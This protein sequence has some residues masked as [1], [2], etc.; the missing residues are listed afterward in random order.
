VTSTTVRLRPLRWWDLDAVLELERDLFEDPWT[1]GMFWSEL[2]EHSTRRYVVAS[3]DDD[4][5][6]IHGYAGL[7]VMGSEAYVQTIGVTRARWGRGLGATLLA[8]LLADAEQRGVDTVL[9]EVRADN[10]RAQ[11]LYQRFGFV[12][13]GVR[14]GYYQPSGTDAVVMVWRS[15]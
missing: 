12:H 14:R 2:A 8:D 5:D 7:A 15:A 11:S 6:R 13:V 10:E 4:D 9:L 1:A 3:I